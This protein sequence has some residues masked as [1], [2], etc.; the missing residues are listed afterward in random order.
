MA[1]KFNFS[2]ADIARILT[3]MQSLAFQ[4]DQGKLP[5]DQT[6]K[7]AAVQVWRWARE[8]QLPD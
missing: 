5:E 2:D 8:T 6:L 4:I 3:L 1:K 7:N